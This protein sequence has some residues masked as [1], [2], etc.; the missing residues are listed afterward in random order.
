MAFS[1]VGVGTTANDGTGDTLRTAFQSINQTI[2]AANAGQFQG[3][4]NQII[5]GDF[6]VAQRGTSFAA[7]TSGNYALDRTAMGNPGGTGVV[8]MSQ[9]LCSDADMADITALTGFAPKHYMRWNQTTEA[10]AGTPHFRHETESIGRFSGRAAIVSFAVRGSASLT[11]A[12]FVQRGT[13][14][15]ASTTYPITTS[16][17]LKTMAF[18]FPAIT[19]A[20]HSD[21]LRVLLGPNPLQGTPTV[22]Y[23]C[24]QLETGA[25]V[26]PFEHRPAQLELA[27]CQRYYQAKTVRSENGSRHIALAPMRS[28][29]S[30]TVGVGSAA[31]ITADGFELSHTTAADCT[32]TASAEL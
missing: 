25:V 23:A 29:P 6:S 13:T 26:T 30:V 28:A 15:I 3:F 24:L 32:V 19:A 22:D 31:N 14:T 1:L 12:M 17:A 10:P 5:N 27:M 4:K 7:I 16:W 9:E 20:Q 11:G 21:Q 8:T 18:T 2:N